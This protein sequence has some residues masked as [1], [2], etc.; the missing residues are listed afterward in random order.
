MV[1]KHHTSRDARFIRGPCSRGTTMGA[2]VQALTRLSP[3]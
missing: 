3:P 2:V 1:L